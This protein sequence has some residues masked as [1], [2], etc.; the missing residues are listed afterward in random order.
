MSS[1]EFASQYVAMYGTA[2]MGT[3][4][5]GPGTT[6]DGQKEYS[7]CCPL[8]LGGVD[9]HVLSWAEV[10]EAHLSATHLLAPAVC[11]RLCWAQEAAL[12]NKGNNFYTVV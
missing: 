4:H 1:Q 8:N 3:A 6:K 2:D 11:Q 12:Q 7:G 9:L 5:M 10:C